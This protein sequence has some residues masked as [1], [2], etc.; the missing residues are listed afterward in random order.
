VN[1]PLDG[2]FARLERVQV[3]IDALKAD[4]PTY[5]INPDPNLP[6]FL[7]HMDFQRR[8]ITVTVSRDVDLPLR[9]A[10]IAGDAIH[11][12]HST[13]DNLVHELGRLTTKT[14][15]RSS[16]FPI[17]NHPN[18]WF[19]EDTRKALTDVRPQDRARIEAH[20][21]FMER[22]D[23]P[24]KHNVLAR[25]KRYSNE[26]KHRTLTLLSATTAEHVMEVANA[27]DCV[28]TGIEAPTDK[29]LRKDAVIASA[30]FEPTGP[31]P[32]VH[33][34]GGIVWYVTLENQE[35]IETFLERAHAYIHDLVV[36]FRNASFS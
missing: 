25:L 6:L 36:E 23:L 32:A 13:L 30:T 9:W 35:P 2:C 27:V 28:I 33:M 26:G 29:K 17:L 4:F 3:H 24:A 1:H 10:V 15:S 31:L 18:E 7:P 11:G 20:Q 14:P 22:G 16:E 34:R 19:T 8:R 21:P 12:L 5:E